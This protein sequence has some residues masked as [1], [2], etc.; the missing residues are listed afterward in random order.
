MTDAREQAKRMAAQ[1][2]VELVEDGMVVGLGTGST[3][4]YVLQELSK[5]VQR[6]LDIRCIGTSAETERLAISGG[7]RLTS[8]AETER[9]DIAI[10]GA[11]EVDANLCLIKGGGGALLR[12]KIV[13]S[14]ADQ[15]VVVVD[16]SKEVDKLGAFRI[17]LEVVP[18]GHEQVGRSVTRLGGQATLRRVS[19]AATLAHHGQ[20][21][22]DVHADDPY[23]T[24]NDHFIYDCDFGLLDH[25]QR[26]HE[27]LKQLVG[28]VETGLFCG[29]A[30]RVILSDGQTVWQRET[31]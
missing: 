31:R 2:A 7:L 29:Y 16:S 18:F 21:A 8:F 4:Y 22:K 27:S 25:P 24:D 9:I 1:A 11:D 19:A 10:D 3:V 23:V 5:R 6:G 20:T 13:A 17:P 14:A 28:V 15:F 26:L 12:E 30:N